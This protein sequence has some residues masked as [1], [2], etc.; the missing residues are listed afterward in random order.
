ML[1]VEV[2]TTLNQD[3]C[4]QY[5]LPLI[6]PQGR[7]G[8]EGLQQHFSLVWRK[9]APGS[10]EGANTFR[11]S[12]N[13]LGSSWP[14]G[15]SPIQVTEFR[16]SSNKVCPNRPWVRPATF[17]FSYQPVLLDLN[18]TV[19]ELF[20]KLYRT[21]YCHVNQVC[22]PH[23]VNLE[24]CARPFPIPP[25]PTPTSGDA[26]SLHRVQPN[27]WAQCWCGE[28]LPGWPRGLSPGP[29]LSWGCKAA[30]PF[31]KNRELITTTTQIPQ[32]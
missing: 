5:S 21:I 32:N 2:C 15:F 28:G 12:S 20:L 1:K 23:S 4:S 22:L 11:R 25:P 16:Q 3:K 7:S 24:T 18:S 14:S 17:V 26:H 13:T 27:M 8:T 19:S 30:G 10:S 6:G 29:C 9:P 31:F